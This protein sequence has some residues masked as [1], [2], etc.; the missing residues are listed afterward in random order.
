MIKN[1]WLLDEV[2]APAP[3]DV[4][5]VR[6]ALCVALPEVTPDPR[7]AAVLI[8]WFTDTAHRDRHSAALPGPR[9]GLLVVAREHALRGADWLARRWHDGGPVLKHMAVARRAP[10]LTPQE[11][12]E[13][14]RERAGRVGAVPVPDPARGRAYVQNH[15]LPG[16]TP[17]DAVNEVYFDDLAGLRT[18]VDWFAAN[19][20]G[21]DDLVGDHWFL[22]VR[23][24][25]HR[26]GSRDRDDRWS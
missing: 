24:E 10:G 13:R 22:A 6:T 18:R 2:P 19:T 1:I 17:F 8:E 25:V 5:P 21:E 4:P 15:P 11:F 16:D 3:A 12:S 26:G 9:P 23:E 7:F 14:W 20:D